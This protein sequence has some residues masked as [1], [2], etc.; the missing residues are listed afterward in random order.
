NEYFSEDPAE[1]SVLPSISQKDNSNDFEMSP[2]KT[3]RILK[4]TNVF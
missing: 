3:I 1:T 4:G 2:V